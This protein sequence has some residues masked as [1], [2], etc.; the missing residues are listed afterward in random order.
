M[1]TPI[2]SVL[3]SEISGREKYGIGTVDNAPVIFRADK[4]ELIADYCPATEGDCFDG[5]C[6]Q[7]GKWVK[8]GIKNFIQRWP[9]DGCPAGRI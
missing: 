8:S 4:K 1:K 5:Y 9:D 7:C 2:I 6:C 3:V